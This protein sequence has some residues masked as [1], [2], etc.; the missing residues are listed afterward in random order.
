MSHEG[1]DERSERQQFK[2]DRVA[3]SDLGTKVT[4]T[5]GKKKRVPAPHEREG[6]PA[7]AGDTTTPQH[8]ADDRPIAAEEQSEDN[9]QKQ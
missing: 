6:E 1:N 7:A 4:S 8:P 9:D 3:D 2:G 5:G